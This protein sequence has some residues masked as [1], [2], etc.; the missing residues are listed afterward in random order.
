MPDPVRG[1]LGRNSR[2]EQNQTPRG[3]SQKEIRALS[4]RRASRGAPG[5][6][7]LNTR[8]RM[9]SSHCPHLGKDWAAC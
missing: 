8:R 5:A 3:P 6:S 4:P 1:W 9:I 2:P 7:R